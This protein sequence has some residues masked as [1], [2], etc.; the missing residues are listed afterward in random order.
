MP[1]V[2]SAEDV[3]VLRERLGSGGKNIQLIAKIDSINGLENFEEILNAA[4]GVVF[5]RNELAWD[6]PSEK[7]NTAQ[8]WALQTASRT[9]KLFMVQS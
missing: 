6:I 2:T 3:T 9:A 8:K 5:Q 1:L 7:L 4:D